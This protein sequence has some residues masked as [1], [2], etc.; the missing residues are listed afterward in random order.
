MLAAPFAMEAYRRISAWHEQGIKK[1]PGMLTII[2]TLGCKG[3]KTKWLI[4]N[5]R[6]DNFRRVRLIWLTV[7]NT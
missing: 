6:L 2:I 7:A 4:K 3:A 5:F 1:F